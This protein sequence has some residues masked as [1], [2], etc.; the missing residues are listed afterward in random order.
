[1]NVLGQPYPYTLII[2]NRGIDKVEKMIPEF[3]QFLKEND[4]Q[5]LK[6][7][8]KMLDSMG[9]SLGV[10]TSMLKEIRWIIDNHQAEFGK[11]IDGLSKKN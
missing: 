10:S 9:I 8:Y 2:T 6:D 1:M 3:I 11:F 7:K 5:E 4:S